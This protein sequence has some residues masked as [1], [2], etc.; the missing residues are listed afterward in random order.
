MDKESWFREGVGGWL[1]GEGS[2]RRA[3]AARCSHL[4]GRR[5][6]SRQ[7]TAGPARPAFPQRGKMLLCTGQSGLNYNGDCRP[8]VNLRPSLIDPREPNAPV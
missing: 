3:A 1:G 6:P 5:G 8:S 2:R 7:C 4:H